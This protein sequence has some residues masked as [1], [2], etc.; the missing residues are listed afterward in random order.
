MELYPRVAMERALKVQEVILRALSKK[1]TW[2]QTTHVALREGIKRWSFT[3][4][5]KESPDDLSTRPDLL[6][7]IHLEHQR[8][9]R[10]VKVFPHPKIG[11]YEKLLPKQRKSNTST[12]GRYAWA[13]FTRWIPG[14]SPLP[15]RLRC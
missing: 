14:P 12:A 3:S 11:T 7:Q 15:P 1:I 6:V 9:R 4:K 8:S 10:R 13:R 5:N 2:M